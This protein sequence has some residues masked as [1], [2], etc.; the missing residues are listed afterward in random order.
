MSFIEKLL[1]IIYPYKCIF[2]HKID[3]D[4]EDSGICDFC[5]EKLK[6]F[7]KDICEKNFVMNSGFSMFLYSSEIREIIHKIKYEDY[8]YY[9]KVMGIKMAEFFVS[10]N[11]IS[12]D[13]IIPVPIHWKRK[14]RRGYNQAEIMA[15]EVSKITKIPISNCSFIRVKNTRPQ[16]DLNKEMRIKNIEGA[17]AIK[18]YEEIVGKDVLFIDD[19][20]TTGTTLREC[21]KVVKS[22]GT[23]NVYYFTLCST[24]VFSWEDFSS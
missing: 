7:D 13:F 5:F 20:Y 21:E 22:I 24:K 12:A 8:G 10:Q 17:F 15:K 9:A 16:F 23:N 4:S 18:S 1:N 14:I 6:V 19:I 11:L 3:F 2:C